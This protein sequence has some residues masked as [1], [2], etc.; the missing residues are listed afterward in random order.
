MDL[1]HEREVNACQMLVGKTERK[2]HSGDIGINAMV[3][4][5]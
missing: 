3:I 1:V 4:S 5:K 2:K